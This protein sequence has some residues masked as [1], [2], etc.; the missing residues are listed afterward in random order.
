MVAGAVAG[1]SDWR[2][3]AHGSPTDEGQRLA[4]VGPGRD[5]PPRARG[6]LPS[7]RVEEER[8]SV[9]ERNNP[10]ALRVLPGPVC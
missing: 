3:V 5:A 2:Q 7:L 4:S 10:D 6:P 8:V 1:R 9:V